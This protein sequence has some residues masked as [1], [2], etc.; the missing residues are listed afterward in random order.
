MTDNIADCPEDAAAYADLLDELAKTPVEKLSDAELLKNYFGQDSRPP[1]EKRWYDMDD[2]GEDWDDDEYY[3]TSSSFKKPRPP[4]PRSAG[5]ASCCAP[6]PPPMGPRINY[7][8][9]YEGPS[10][11][12]DSVLE[13]V[14]L[15]GWSV[16]KIQTQLNRFESTSGNVAGRMDGVESRMRTLVAGQHTIIAML[17]EIQRE[18]SLLRESDVRRG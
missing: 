5:D 16:E 9:H 11:P 13:R 3:M 18:V 15:I 10:Y 6:K 17:A 8:N 7:Q 2:F 4:P 12:S 1:P 14:R